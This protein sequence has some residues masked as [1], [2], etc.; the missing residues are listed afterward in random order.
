MSSEAVKQ[1]CTTDLSN[2]RSVRRFYA[3]LT[4]GLA[5]SGRRSTLRA[6]HRLR[7]SRAVERCR[8]RKRHRG[9]ER[10]GAGAGE[11]SEIRTA[12]DY[13][14]LKKCTCERAPFFGA[15]SPERSEGP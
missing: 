5:R 3:A 4:V 12:G 15:P 14:P 10:V 13:G 9:R 7:L 2:L 8:S 11:R 1:H 6:R